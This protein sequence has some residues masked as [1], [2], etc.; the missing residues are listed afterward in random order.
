M[1]FLEDGR[2]VDIMHTDQ[3]FGHSRSYEHR[4]GVGNAP[5]VG[6]GKP[7]LPRDY[8]GFDGATEEEIEAELARAW[9]INEAWRVTGESLGMAGK[10]EGLFR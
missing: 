10:C 9:M 3:L 5:G 8:A 7:W 6:G 4:P 1:P 2:P